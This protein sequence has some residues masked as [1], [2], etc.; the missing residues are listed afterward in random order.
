MTT[1]LPP[2]DAP[3]TD[4]AP[5]DPYP[6]KAIAAAVTTLVTAA[7]QWI[8]SGSLQL[9]QEGITVIGGAVA[10]VLVY[11]ISNWKRRGA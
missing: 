3:L 4:P 11:V 1:Y 5:T 9:D 10:T 7:V 6:N 2:P 8:V